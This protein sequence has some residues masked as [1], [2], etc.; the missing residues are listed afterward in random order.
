MK[1]S[2]VAIH[3]AN[4]CLI[5]IAFPGFCRLLVIFLTVTV[6]IQLLLARKHAE[7]VNYMWVYKEQWYMKNSPWKAWNTST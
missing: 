2:L 7:K 6:Y 1:F 4:F 3:L 5:I